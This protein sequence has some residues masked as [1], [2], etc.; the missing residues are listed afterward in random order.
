MIETYAMDDD[1]NLVVTW[2]AETPGDTAEL[3]EHAPA[4]DHG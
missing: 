3:M 1:G 4:A 2:E